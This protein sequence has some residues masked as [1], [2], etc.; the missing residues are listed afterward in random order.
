M[1]ELLG[2]NCNVPTDI[3]FSFKGF[4]ER[5]GRTH[6]HGDGWGIAF[7]EGKGVR[8]FLD[9]KSA[10]DSPIAKMVT[11]YSIK[12]LNVIA[13]IRQATVGKNCL[14]N[15]HPFL[16]E[17]WGKNIV[18]AHNG[19]LIDFP[20]ITEGIYIPIGT[21]D[22]ESAFCMILNELKSNFSSLPKPE[23]F[24]AFLQSMADKISKFGTFNF[25]MGAG[26][27]Y[28]YVHSTIN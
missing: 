2:M 28:L 13:H 4:C 21:T 26:D 18:F 12:S 1:C 5:G 3:C 20:L 8:I 27:D 9:E 15:T 7:Y 19:D 17:L 6:D 25:L 14:E 16:R 11:D 10:C 22:S 24:R 23:E